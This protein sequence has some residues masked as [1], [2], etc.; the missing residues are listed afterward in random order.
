MH[1]HAGG[2][3]IE[4]EG[5]GEV[6]VRAELEQVDAVGGGGPRGDDDHRQLG[7]ALA[8]RRDEFLACGS[9]KHKVADDQI[10]GQGGTLFVRRGGGFTGARQAASQP[11]DALGP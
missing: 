8:H 10:E 9:E 6:V 2:E 5:L 7:V 3:L 1:P 11:H 4:V